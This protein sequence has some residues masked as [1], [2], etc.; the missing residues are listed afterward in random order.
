VQLWCGL[1]CTRRLDVSEAHPHK[2]CLPYTDAWTACPPKAAKG[3][4]CTT[5]QH[6][7]QG[8]SCCRDESLVVAPMWWPTSLLAR[9]DYLC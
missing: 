2:T 3:P 5:M 6:V 4:A 9:L 1:I 7:R 8:E